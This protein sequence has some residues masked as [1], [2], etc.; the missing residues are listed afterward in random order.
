MITDK[1]MT[2]TSLSHKPLDNANQIAITKDDLVGVFGEMEALGVNR[3]DVG[4]VMYMITRRYK[5]DP[6]R[7][8]AVL[9]RYQ[10]LVRLLEEEGL[11]G[12]ELPAI[13]ER[14]AAPTG[15]LLAAAAIEPLVEIG[16]EVA[17]EHDAFIRK[18]LE[19]SESAGEA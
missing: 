18:V 3:R 17:F 8:G 7:A 13:N 16:N 4:A 11:P 19:L 6:S 10:A 15:A 5:Y 12:W 2:S 14:P 9:L 1:D